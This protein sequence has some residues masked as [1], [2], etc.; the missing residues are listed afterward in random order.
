MARSVVAITG[1]SSGIGEVFARKLAPEHD[2][3]LIARRRERL[4]TLASEFERSFGCKSQVLAADLSSDDGLESAA[5]VLVDEPRL[6]LLINNAGFGS[7]GR[8]WEKPYELEQKMHQVHITATLRLSHAAL[9]QMVKNDRGAIINVASVAAFVRNAGSVS[10]GATKSWMTAFTE[11]LYVELK[12]VG[13][14]VAVQALCPGFTYSEF[15]DV[16][17]VDRPRMAPRQFWM[18]AE[19]VVDAS[20]AGLARGQLFVIPGWRYRL[21][22][23][24]ISKLPSSLR[25]RVE[26][27]AGRSRSRQLAA[28]GGRSEIGGPETR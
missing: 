27:L 8:F 13:S 17:G 15:H 24:F 3:I 26:L 10:Y 7:K 2:L 12:S 21:L 14:N 11:G 9:Q 4:E 23:A 16:M 20:L 19:D 18:R 5:K 28:S 1:A 25:V 22:T 6:V